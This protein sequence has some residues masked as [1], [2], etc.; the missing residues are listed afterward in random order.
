[1]A[2]SKITY[3]KFKKFSKD[4]S[5]DEIK[6]IN[7]EITDFNESLLAKKNKLKA[8]YGEE[9]LISQMHI[10]DHDKYNFSKK[11]YS[12]IMLEF[13]LSLT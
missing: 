12:K 13:Y 4:F 5:I 1:M 2:S 9:F 3:S 6:S 10:G 8:I 11:N 7:E